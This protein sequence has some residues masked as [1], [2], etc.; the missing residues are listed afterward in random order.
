MP[1][2][3]AVRNLAVIAIGSP[4]MQGRVVQDPPQA[5]LA[6]DLLYG[7]SVAQVAHRAAELAGH[8]LLGF[9]QA[10]PPGH[11]HASHQVSGSS[12][13]AYARGERVV[14]SIPLESPEPTYN[15][16]QRS[17]STQAFAARDAASSGG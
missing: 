5:L 15:P 3:S 9:L 14:T 7:V 2:S 12:H 11:L 13:P 1:S 16:S 6:P 8:V 10:H 17:M 4:G